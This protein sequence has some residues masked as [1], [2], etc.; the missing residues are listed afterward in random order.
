MSYVACARMSNL[1][2]R[3]PLYTL[4]S[5]QGLTVSYMYVHVS[6]YLNASWFGLCALDDRPGL[7][8]AGVL[9][10]T[11][12]S[13]RGKS[14]ASRFQSL[15]SAR[16]HEASAMQVPA[17][18]QVMDT[19]FRAASRNQVRELAASRMQVQLARLPQVH[20]KCIT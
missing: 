12:G 1:Q 10:H 8:A 14:V 3:K 20:G 16:P 17:S 19:L 18:G 4:A 5:C 15:A 13:G 11:G 6:P 9:E 2:R 7:K